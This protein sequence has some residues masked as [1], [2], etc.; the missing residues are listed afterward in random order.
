MSSRDKDTFL[1]LDE[2]LSAEQ[3][4][5]GFKSGNEE[6]RDQV[7]ATMMEMLEDGTFLEIATK[8][9]LQDSVC[10]GE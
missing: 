8:W 5:I 6:L 1:I 2:Y 10:L 3:Y 9:D 4:G 7:E